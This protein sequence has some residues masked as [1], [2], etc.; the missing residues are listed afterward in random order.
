MKPSASSLTPAAAKQHTES[1]ELLS[2]RGV[3]PA[4]ATQC[5]SGSLGAG[6]SPPAPPMA[7]R[8]PAPAERLLPVISCLRLSWRALCECSRDVCCGWRSTGEAAPISLL[9]PVRKGCGGEPT[10]R[11]L[12][13]C[14][15]SSLPE[16]KITPS[17]AALPADLSAQ[18]SRSSLLLCKS[19]C[20]S[21]LLCTVFFAVP[22]T[23]PAPTG[24]KWDWGSGEREMPAGRER[25]V[26]QGDAG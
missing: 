24:A 5:C 17:P 7:F 15:Q 2:S 8:P 6:E 13:S 19:S 12:T 26:T 10:D 3:A 25:R 18:I 11:S 14:C 4:P 23:K 1:S 21:G 16:P 20:L 22:S 9:M